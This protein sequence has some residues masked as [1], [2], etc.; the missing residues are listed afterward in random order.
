MAW[1]RIGSRPEEED[2]VTPP[3][4]RLIYVPIIHG[5]ADLGRLAGPVQRFSLALFGEERWRA[6]RETVSRFWDSVGAFFEELRFSRLKVYQDGLMAGGELGLKIIEEGAKAGSQNHRVLLRL[7]QR[8]AEIMK[9]EDPSLLVEEYEWLRQMAESGSWFRRLRLALA[10]QIRK[11]A[12]MRKRDRY[13][14]RQIDETLEGGETGIL[15]MGAF[16][17]VVSWL[18]RDLRVEPLKDPAKVRA[19]FGGLMRRGNETRLACLARYFAA[20][21]GVDD[22]VRL[23]AGPA[24]PKK[25]GE[26]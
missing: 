2:R 12:L 10:Y 16:H 23:A 17:D 9:T 26:P 25:E 5:E 24:S 7:V 15:F 1:E 14:A 21:I 22:G 3:G 13:I 11:K 8:G 4:R 6:H 18:P 20:P 19:Y